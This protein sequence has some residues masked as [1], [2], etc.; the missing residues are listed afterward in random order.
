MDLVAYVAAA[1]IAAVLEIVA[2]T[3]GTIIE[4]ITN[5]RRSRK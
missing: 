1:V 2:I 3:A 5:F 4:R